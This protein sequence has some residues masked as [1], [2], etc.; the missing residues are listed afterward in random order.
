V[1]WGSALFDDLAHAGAEHLDPAY[2]AAYDEKA[3]FDA[4]PSKSATTTARSRRTTS[5]F[6]STRLLQ[7]AR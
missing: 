6:A 1:T 7:A 3:G 5:G 4:D 2:V